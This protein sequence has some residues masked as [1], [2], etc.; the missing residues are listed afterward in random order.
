MKRTGTVLAV[1]LMVL[2][3]ATLVAG[4]SNIAPN[5]GADQRSLKWR[6][7]NWET[8]PGKFRWRMAD[9]WGDLFY[10]QIA[11]HFADSVRA[12][13]GGRLDIKLYATGSAVAASEIFDAT[14][15]GA[16]DA[17]HAPPALWAE[18]NVAFI[19]LSAVPFG[20]D[21]T[22]YPL[23]YYEG[24]GKELLQALYSRYGLTGFLCGTTGVQLGLRSPRPI[25]GLEDMQGMQIGIPAWF[26]W[27]GDIFRALGA[28]PVT[29]PPSTIPQG[30]AQGQLGAGVVGGPALSHF[31][32]LNQIA[33]FAVSATAFQPPNHFNIVFNKQKFD[34]LP[35]DLK[36]ILEICAYET[37][38]WARHWIGDLNT[39]VIDA[40]QQSTVQGESGEMF[41]GLLV[42]TASR[43]ISD[44]MAADPDAQRILSSQIAFFR[45]R[46]ALRRLNSSVFPWIASGYNDLE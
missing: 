16:L 35:D 22:S 45:Q 33:P 34:A 42:E 13:S 37:D 43:L 39:D 11:L 40:L 44:Q 14:A 36:A 31:L 1:L 30:L 38:L 28:E 29:M 5:F 32:Q 25:E 12:A 24:G 15:R 6:Y 10:R 18:K 46:T 41:R 3:I 26:N 8:S 27:Y 23:W 9:P 20:L 21:G 19:A 4:D 7:Q 17:F 2:A